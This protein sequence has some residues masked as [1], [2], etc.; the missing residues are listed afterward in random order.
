[1]TIVERARYEKG[2]RLLL[3]PI[4]LCLLACSQQFPGESVGTYQV[5]GALEENTCGIT[6]FYVPDPL[7]MVVELRSDTERAY[8]MPEGQPM[9]QGIPQ[10]EDSYRFRTQGTAQLADA[11]P[12]NGYPPCVVARAETIEVSVVEEELLADGGVQDEEEEEAEPTLLGT[13]LLEIAPMPDTYC[14]PFL[15]THG[16]TFETL[17]CQI[18][19]ELTGFTK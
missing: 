15:A 2:M 4:L 7:E 16:G 11:D 19:Y 1:L 9:L 14:L 18:S 13:Q 17:P 8:Y 6:T 5:T 3:L 10:A 12:I